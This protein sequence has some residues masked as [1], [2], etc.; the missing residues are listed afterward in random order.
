MKRSVLVLIISLVC[1]SLAGIMGVQFFWIR[2]A[3]RL[4]EEQFD[5]SV[6]D[7]MVK[8]VNMLETRENISYIGRN[9]EGD[10]I[11]SFTRSYSHDST[12]SK[13]VRKKLDSLMTSEDEMNPLPSHP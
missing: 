8:T 1:L 9:Y 2:N 6:N 7:A 12:Y 10:S 11:L 13:I 5:R 3:I 4:K